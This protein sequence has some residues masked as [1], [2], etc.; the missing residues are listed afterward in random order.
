MT[1]LLLLITSILAWSTTGRPS[2]RS[3]LQL[4]RI[5]R[6]SPLGLASVD[7][8]TTTTRPTV[9]KT[10]SEWRKQLTEDQFYVLRQQG[11]ERPFTSDLNSVKKDGIFTCAGCGE[12]LFI[13]ST[14]FDSGTGWPSFYAPVD[15][16][17]V[18]MN[19][20][21]KAGLPRTE[22][23]CARCSGHLG[24]VFP[25][26][27]KPTGQRFCING[28]AMEFRTDAELDSKVVEE[29]AA[30]VANAKPMN[31]PEGSQLPQ[32]ALNG[33]LTASFLSSFYSRFTSL[34]G[35]P[36]SVLDGS[37]IVIFFRVYPLVAGLWF[38][39]QFGKVVLKLS[40][41]SS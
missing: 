25:D 9:T 11:T 16:Q 6:L 22:C 5:G 13:T 29:V 35:G 32:V 21:Y 2:T 40:R 4:Q 38:L 41:S 10:D 33:I 20:D 18:T 12:P 28:V 23:R 34:E 24:H 39:F 27:P 26:G 1:C 7:P 8:E 15:D 30:R 36:S 14:K 31:V 17:A 3:R 37:A 19:V